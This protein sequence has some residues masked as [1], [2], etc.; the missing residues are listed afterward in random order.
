MG[1]VLEFVTIGDKEYRVIKTGR[2]QAEQVA[3]LTRW[4]SVHGARAIARV[5][6][7]ANLMG[8][9]LSGVESFVRF[10]G[11]LDADAIIDLF[12]VLTGCTKEEAEVYFDIAIMVDVAIEVYNRQTS[13]RRL[14]DRFFSQSNSGSTSEEP[15]TSSE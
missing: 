9:N 11:V 6:E 1:E 15:S 4:L 14:L 10:L 5:Q 8:E 2:A 3:H 7:D 12:I 13:L